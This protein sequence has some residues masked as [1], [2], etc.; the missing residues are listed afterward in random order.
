MN[1]KFTTM[2]TLKINVVPTILAV[3][4]SILMAY[5][6]Y[7]YTDC[8]ANKWLVAVGGGVMS[9]GSLFGLMGFTKEPTRTMSLMRVLSLLFFVIMLISSVVFCSIGEFKAPTYVIVNGAIFLI[10]VLTIYYTSKTSL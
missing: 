1:K 5:A 6:L 7:V 3:A 4:L 10:Y 9:L 2:T 8:A